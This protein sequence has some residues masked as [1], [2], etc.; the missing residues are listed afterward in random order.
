LIVGVQEAH[1]ICASAAGQLA[2]WLAR[3]KEPPAIDYSRLAEQLQ[4][5]VDTLRAKAQP[6]LL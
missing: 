1:R 5:V 2:L 6:P 4:N 3:P